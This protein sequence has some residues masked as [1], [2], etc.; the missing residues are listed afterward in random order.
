[1]RWQGLDTPNI[2]RIK[3][4][5]RGLAGPGIKTLPLRIFGRTDFCKTKKNQFSQIERTEVYLTL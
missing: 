5:Q 3:H 2:A 4:Y 1:M